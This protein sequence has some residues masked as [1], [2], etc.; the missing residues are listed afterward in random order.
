MISVEQLVEENGRES[1]GQLGEM[2]AQCQQND[3]VSRVFVDAAG[4]TAARQRVC[5]GST[6]SWS[7]DK[8]LSM[9]AARRVA[10]K[11]ELKDAAAGSACCRL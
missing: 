11:H 9:Q 3:S 7:S 1:A 6:W 4:C 5:A 10:R 8:L 2:S